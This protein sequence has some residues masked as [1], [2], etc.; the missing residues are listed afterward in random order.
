MNHGTRSHSSTSSLVTVNESP[1]QVQS[2]YRKQI[3]CP[4][5][6]GRPGTNI[7]VIRRISWLSAEKY[8]NPQNILVICRIFAEYFA[9]YLSPAIELLLCLLP[10]CLLL[11]ITVALF[12]LI[13]S[14]FVEIYS[15]SLSP[16]AL[17]WQNLSLFGPYPPPPGLCNRV[18]CW[19]L[20]VKNLSP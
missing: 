12:T 9:E 2:C 20:L 16:T 11:L 17:R 13:T 14:L 18:D 19:R 7:M 4:G 8:G 10:C 6:V 3:S 5:S 1:A 15:P